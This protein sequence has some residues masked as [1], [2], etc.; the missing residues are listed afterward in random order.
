MSEK[1]EFPG[2]DINVTVGY[3]NGL[4]ASITFALTSEVLSNDQQIKRGLQ[5]V[6]GKLVELLRIASKSLDENSNESLL[7][8]LEQQQQQQ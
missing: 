3:L 6:G 4:L 7:N 1:N 2:D 8:E 5:I